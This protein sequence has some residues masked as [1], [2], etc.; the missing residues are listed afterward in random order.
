[1][2]GVTARSGP[3][4]DPDELRGWA[5]RRNL[6]EDARWAMDTVLSG[7]KVPEFGPYVGL[8]LS[9]HFVRIAYEGTAAIRSGNPHVG[10]PVLA[11]LLNDTFAR[12]TANARHLT[13]MLDNNKK[14]YTDI[15]SESQ[16]S[17]K[18][19]MTR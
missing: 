15:L 13:K 4:L 12:I 10:I 17:W 8:L 1:M 19:T 14:S 16:P 7:N 11:A 9:H 3:G 5:A 6:A 18:S 2:T